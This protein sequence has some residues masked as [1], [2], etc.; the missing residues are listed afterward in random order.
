M[1]WILSLS[2][3]LVLLTSYNYIQTNNAS[4]YIKLN[5]IEIQF[6]DIYEIK[7]D[8][9]YFYYTHYGDEYFLLTTQSLIGS[10]F[11]LDV[12]HL[13]VVSIKKAL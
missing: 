11:K 9:T 8:T 10:E 3:I 6:K 5:K 1:K 13:K 7:S 4:K 2:I 12:N